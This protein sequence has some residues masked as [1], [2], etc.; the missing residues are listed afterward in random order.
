MIG[1]TLCSGTKVCTTCKTEKP[2]SEFHR[3]GKRGHHC[4]CKPCLKAR[5]RR[6]KK[7][8]RTE[9]NL[10]RRYGLT[11]N[12]RDKML[13]NQRGCAICGEDPKRP[14]VDHCHVSGAVRGVLCHP[15]NIKLH[16]VEDEKFR[17]AAMAYLARSGAC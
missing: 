3:M 17:A 7:Y 4:Y 10:R 12:E 2:L 13:L 15:C 6:R 14:V 9:G 16:A 5:P 8:D 11:V 1:M